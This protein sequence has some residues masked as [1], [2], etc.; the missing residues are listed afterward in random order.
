MVFRFSL[1]DLLR[2]RLSIERNFEIRLIA[3]Q[4][5]VNSLAQQI[6]DIDHTAAS[7]SESQTAAIRAPHPAAT[8]HFYSS[9]ADALLAQRRVL[10]RQRDEAAQTR[11]EC[12]AAYQK[13]RRDREVLEI[14]CDEEWQA[15]RR[16]EARREQR[17]ADDLH[18][19]LLH[20]RSLG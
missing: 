3:A 7:W 16:L 4:Q 11:N 12:A 2:L 14:L 10:C 19:L 1:A 5:H 20:R 15:H 17:S 6:V 8:L 9:C 13:A 18:L